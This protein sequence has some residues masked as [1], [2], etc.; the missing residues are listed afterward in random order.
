M[1]LK[2]LAVLAKKIFWVE[3]DNYV[4]FAKKR[5]G[6]IFSKTIFREN[7]I[8]HFRSNPSANPLRT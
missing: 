1:S 5:V 7:F 8:R 3:T 6:I 4:N 2:K